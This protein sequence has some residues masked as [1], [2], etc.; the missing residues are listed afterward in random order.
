[1]IV[2]TSREL[3]ICVSQKAIQKHRAKPFY[4]KNMKI[5]EDDIKWNRSEYHSIAEIV[6]LDFYDY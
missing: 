6:K 2:K 1:M 5:I 3:L 4:Q